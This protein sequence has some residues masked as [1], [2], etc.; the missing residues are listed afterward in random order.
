MQER[1]CTDCYCTFVYIAFW[2]V[3]VG[4][5]CAAFWLGDPTLQRV[6][7][8]TD[9]NGHT[10]GVD[11]SH[12]NGPNLLDR[13][14][15]IYPRM[16]QDVLMH[17]YE[18][19]TDAEG[20]NEIVENPTQLADF[21]TDFHPFGVCVEDCPSGGD[22][23]CTYEWDKKVDKKAIQEC[24][25]KDGLE[26]A[27]DYLLSKVD[28]LGG[29][30]CEEILANCFPTPVDNQDYFFRCLPLYR[31]GK[32]KIEECVEW[33]SDNNTDKT[34]HENYDCLA[35]KVTELKETIK[36][37]KGDFLLDVVNDQVQI[38]NNILDDFFKAKFV[39]ITVGFI[40]AVVLSFVWLVI[41]RFFAVVIVW[42][43]IVLVYILCGAA[44]LLCY[45][46]SD[47]VSGTDIG[48]L[49]GSLDSAQAAVAAGMG[50]QSGSVLENVTAPM[51]FLFDS[52]HAQ[53]WKYVAYVST[54]VYVIFIIFGLIML[55]KV[56]VAIKIIVETTN[57]IKD[58]PLIMIWPLFPS[59]FILVM[60]VYWLYTSMFIGSMGA[61]KAHHVEALALTSLGNLTSPT[62]FNNATIVDTK[63][64]TALDLQ[65][66]F[67]IFNVFMVMW[68]VGLI[69]AISF[70][71]MAGAFC[72]WYWSRG[73]EKLRETF[74]LCRAYGRVM[75]YHFG[76][77][78]VGSFILATIRLVRFVMMYLE[79]KTRAAQRNNKC[80]QT[81]FKVVHCMLFLFDKCLKYLAR[82]AYIMVAMY[83]YNFCKASIMAVMLI[84]SNVLQV[85]AVNAINRY[86][87]L[88]GKLVV[89]VSCVIAGY[90]WVTYSPDFQGENELF[91]LLP[92]LAVVGIFG[93]SVASYVFNIYNVGVETILLCFCQ[94][95][96]I[97]ENLGDSSTKLFHSGMQEKIKSITQSDQFQKKMAPPVE[98]IE[99]TEPLTKGAAQ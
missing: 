9:Y 16:M 91:A 72:R 86:V 64:F 87:M 80:V 22:Y 46:K 1:K 75:Q 51:D 71:T 62:L 67:Q 58:M 36:P 21:V 97:H 83:G 38:V 8:G 19:A 89:V 35:V 85:A 55:K 14:R 20:I 92:V 25:M 40:G 65:P 26:L 76:T 56:V 88:L 34:V 4:I 98:E 11:H 70:T 37:A 10:C 28:G 60:L 31:T 78:A 81:L 54:G 94:D 48:N 63:A 24:Y 96:M 68:T 52:Q 43:S 49:M 73:E 82:Q 17:A 5:L 66:A 79:K 6:F 59:A 32:E 93:L 7:Y 13:K 29:K 99:L 30:N 47:L 45:F 53:T 44:V 77:M 61:V 84:T 41:L 2:T 57:A 23:V 12:E 33:Y 39:I 74:P 95:C 90:M 42:A 69:N 18:F 50:Q 15:I 3:M 27:A